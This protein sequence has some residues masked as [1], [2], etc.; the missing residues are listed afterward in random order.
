MAWTVR[1]TGP[2]PGAEAE[3]PA[4]AGC[5]HS[6]LSAVQFHTGPGGKRSQW[7]AS[8]GC[9]AGAA[10]RATATDDRCLLQAGQ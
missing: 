6:H 8:S 2:R 7:W 4:Q 1:S 5:E 9:A 3:Q 10:G